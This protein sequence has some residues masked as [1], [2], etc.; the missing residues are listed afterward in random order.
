M[1]AGLGFFSE[2]HG[3]S[4]VIHK[5]TG[6]D[7]YTTVV[8]NNLF[9]NLMAAE[10]LRVAA[11]AVDRLR[12]ESPPDFRRVVERTGLADDEPAN[13]RRAA[14]QIYVPYDEAAGVHLQD[15]GFLD[16]APWDFAG[17]APDRYPLLLHFHP[18]V[19][20]RHQ[21]IKQADVVLATVMLPERFSAEERRRIFDYYD[22]LTTGDSS[23]S[24]CI[25]AIAAAD[26]GKYRSAE[27]YLID[28]VAVDMAD[29]AGNLRDG[30]HVASA[31]GTWMAVVYGFAGYRWRTD[32]PEFSPM[33]PTQGPPAALPAA[34]AGLAARGGHRG[35][36][37]HLPGPLRG[38]VT[39]RHD[40]RRFTASTDAPVSFPGAL[41]HPRPGRLGLGPPPRP[42]CMWPPSLGGWGP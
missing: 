41:P 11:D 21:V 17:T 19:I 20:Y 3:G 15:D 24:E 33:L 18:L 32:V 4:F 5:V 28:A 16:Q 9:T 23:L 29:T 1:W 14:E 40:G 31:G 2:R 35:G 37:R 8:D 7:E 42:D 10:N 22:P 38:P 34:A 39:A 27:E 12:T 36:G 26:A 30:M 13:W 6:P 25:Q